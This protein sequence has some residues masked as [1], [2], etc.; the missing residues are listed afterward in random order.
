M[1]PVSRKHDARFLRDIK[2]IL[3]D[4]DGVVRSQ[5]SRAED[6]EYRQLCRLLWG[7]EG[8]TDTTVPELVSNFAGYLRTQNGEAYEIRYAN[9]GG[10]LLE[11]VPPK[12]VPNCRIWLLANEGAELLI[13]M[14]D[15]TG[16]DD[17]HFPDLT[18]VVGSRLKDLFPGS[19]VEQAS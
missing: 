1:N 12:R 9:W 10:Q 3:G 16:I 19:L 2:E 11:L 13:A 8:G 6:M 18:G 4:K 7:S 15:V 5:P 14:K 17:G